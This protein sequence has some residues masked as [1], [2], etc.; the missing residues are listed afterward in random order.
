M[1]EM[2]IVDIFTKLIFDAQSH[3]DES[4]ELIYQLLVHHEESLLKASRRDVSEYLRSM[5]VDEMI[6]TVAVLQAEYEK[7]KGLVVA[8]KPRQGHPVHR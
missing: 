8:S 1:D 6:K 2:S 4:E 3:L 5:G 7:Q